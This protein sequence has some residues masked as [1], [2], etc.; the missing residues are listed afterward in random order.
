MFGQPRGDGL[1]VKHVEAAGDGGVGDRDGRQ[2]DRTGVGL[3]NGVG[4]DEGGDECWRGR[5]DGDGFGFDDGRRRGRRM[6]KRVEVLQNAFGI[7][8]PPPEGQRL[9]RAGMN[10]DGVR[11]VAGQTHRIVGATQGDDGNGMWIEH[12]VDPP[13]VIAPFRRR[14]VNSGGHGARCGAVDR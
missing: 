12:G 11:G 3:G 7:P 13:R 9:R 2:G 14:M 4:D 1:P 10:V 8:T 6:E 5:R